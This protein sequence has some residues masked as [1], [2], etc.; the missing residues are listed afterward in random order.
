MENIKQVSQE[1]NH[2][3]N[4]LEDDKHVIWQAINVEKDKKRKLEV[5]STH[6]GH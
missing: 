6:L 1:R 5:D 2:L 4:R 3:V